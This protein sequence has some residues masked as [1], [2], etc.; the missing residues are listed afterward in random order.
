MANFFAESHAAIVREGALEHGVLGPSESKSRLITVLLI[1]A[2]AA[3]ALSMLFSIGTAVLSARAQT[4]GA[5]SDQRTARLVS[6]ITIGTTPA[7]V[8]GGIASN[9]HAQDAATPGIAG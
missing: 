9:T 8:L 1:A 2:I 3:S 4:E 6:S 7:G 5:A